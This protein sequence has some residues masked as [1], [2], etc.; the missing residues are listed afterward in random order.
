MTTPVASE[1]VC[2]C[3]GKTLLP[4]DD[5]SLCTVC[6]ET[7]ERGEC[8]TQCGQRRSGLVRLNNSCG[9]IAGRNALVP[10]EEGS[11]GWR[12]GVSPSSSAKALTKLNGGN[13]S[14]GGGDGSGKWGTEG[15][16]SCIVGSVDPTD[17]EEGHES[18]ATAAAV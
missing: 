18:G 12:R 4:G 10:A 5:G 17:D 3:G 14:A 16:G 11:A 15:K 2:S 1:A 7:E 13:T 8:G 9:G 6:D